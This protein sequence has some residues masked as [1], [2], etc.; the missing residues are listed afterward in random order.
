ME[1]VNFQTALTQADGG[2]SS[3]QHDTRSGPAIQPA[4]PFFYWRKTGF[5][6]TQDNLGEYNRRQEGHSP[7]AGFC[8]L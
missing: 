6:S 8:V 2:G 4:R 7:E 1:A 3:W 5:A